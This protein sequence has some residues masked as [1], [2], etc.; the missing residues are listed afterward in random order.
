MTLSS[1]SSASSPER[2]SAAQSSVQPTIA[3]IGLGKVGTVLGRALHQAGYTIASVSSRD[4]A[5]AERV[6]TMLCSRSTTAVEAAQSA[7]ITLLTISD[8]AI[9]S[10]AA[11]LADLGAWQPQRAVVHASGASPASVLAPAAAHGSTIGAFHPLAA[12]ASPDTTLPTGLTFAIEAQGQLHQH[13]W[14]MA[15]NLGG[16]PLALDPAD[17]TLYHA[18]AVIASNYTVTLTAL[19]TQLFEHMGATP[20]QALRALLP[21]MR[22]T[23]DNME[24]RG[25]PQALTGPLLRGDVVTVQRH[26]LAL[27]QSAPQVGVLYRCLAQGTLPL[28]QRRGLAAESAGALQDMITLPRELLVEQDG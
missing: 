1:D 12:F 8:D 28:A 5:K 24:R 6:A 25:L 19:A 17:K 21:L 13:L 23:L 16:H 18:A 15:Q 7:D 2:S 10:F 20:E 11:Q 27:D 22:T 3:I 26:L 9:P 14:A 4:H